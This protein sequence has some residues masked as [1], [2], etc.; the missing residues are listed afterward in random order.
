M[1]VLHKCDNRKCCNPSHLFLG[2]NLDNIA[3]KLAKGRQARGESS[4]LAKLR[5]RDIPIIRAMAREG[6]SQGKIARVFGVTLQAI[7]CVV[8]GK[9]WRDST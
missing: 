6:V 2:T 9:T 3:D 4:A 8:K 1:C 5:A 7:W